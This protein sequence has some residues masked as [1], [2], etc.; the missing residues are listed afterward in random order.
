MA[1]KKNFSALLSDGTRIKVA[2]TSGN[3]AIQE[4]EKVISQTKPGVTVRSVCVAVSF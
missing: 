3:K 4:A 2:A 1:A